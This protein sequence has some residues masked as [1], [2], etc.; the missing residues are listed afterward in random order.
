ML[1]FKEGLIQL[2]DRY[3]IDE[4]VFKQ[5]V[6]TDRS[7]LGKPCLAA[8]E[9][10]DLFCEELELLCPHSFLAKEQA[11]YFS[12]RKSTLQVGEILVLQDAAQGFHWNNSQATIYPICYI[13]QRIT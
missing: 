7:T 6:S 9:F 3:D 5:C 2:L 1:N 4:I 10:V 11:T 8:D 13:L 12:W